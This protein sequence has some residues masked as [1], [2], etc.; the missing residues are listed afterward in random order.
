MDSETNM[1]QNQ[2]NL[3]QPPIE[4]GPNDPEQWLIREAG[5]DEELL[6]LLKQREALFEETARTG[7]GGLGVDNEGRSKRM[8]ELL[9]EIQ[10]RKY[11]PQ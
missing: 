11:P 8:G 4:Q 5:G 6:G 2:N 10:A 1:N 9:D 3:G 7:Q